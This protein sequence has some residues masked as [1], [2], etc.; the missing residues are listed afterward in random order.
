MDLSANQVGG[1]TQR[2]R[3]DGGGPTVLIGICHRFSQRQCVI[4]IEMAWKPWIG[5]HRK[6]CG[7]RSCGTFLTI[8]GNE[9]A[10]RGRAECQQQW[11]CS[12]RESHGCTYY[13]LYQDYE[14]REDMQWQIVGA[15]RLPPTHLFLEQI[16]L[17][18]PVAVE[19][20]RGAGGTGE[21]GAGQLSSAN[22]TYERG[23]RGEFW[24]QRGRVLV[25]TWRRSR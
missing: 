14:Q 11:Q 20:G 6:W 2:G 7:T 25:V 8:R 13:A 17:S 5:T 24:G 16:Y 15:V 22:G 19:G 23:A 4:H 3:G 9:Q 1:K 18:V 12:Q 21:Q 10:V